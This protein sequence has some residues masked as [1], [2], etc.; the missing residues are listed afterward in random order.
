MSSVLIVLAG[1]AAA[2]AL[3]RYIQKSPDLVK[4]DVEQKGDPNFDGEN[5][6]NPGWDEEQFIEDQKQK[7]DQK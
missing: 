7:L 1:I 3:F 6:E 2:V 5:R 4:P